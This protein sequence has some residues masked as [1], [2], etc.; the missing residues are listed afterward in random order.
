MSNDEF[1]KHHAMQIFTKISA[2]KWGY[3]HQ[4]IVKEVNILSWEGI[5]YS[6]PSQNDL[7]RNSRILRADIYY[8]CG[9]NKVNFTFLNP[10]FFI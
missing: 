7:I 3:E 8:L 4:Y 5:Y 10:N 9:M 1:E 2:P 6:P